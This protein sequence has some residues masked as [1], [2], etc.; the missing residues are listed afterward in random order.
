MKRAI[1]AALAAILAATAALTAMAQ[2]PRSE[3]G[4]LDSER[5][6]GSNVVVRGQ[7]KRCVRIRLHRSQRG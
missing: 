2:P 6:G 1:V 7:Y 4:T 3:S 5:G